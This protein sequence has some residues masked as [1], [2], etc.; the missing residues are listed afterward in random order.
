VPAGA[1]SPGDKV[2]HA[3]FGE[4]VVLGL[5]P[6]GVVSVFFPD[7]GEKKRLSLDYAPLRKL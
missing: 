5:E 4:G 1:F 7:T 6:G 3:K 2:L